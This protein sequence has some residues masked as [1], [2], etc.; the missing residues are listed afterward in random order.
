[1][2][3]PSAYAALRARAALAEEK[4]KIE[5]ATYTDLARQVKRLTNENASLKED[6]AFF[7]SL[8]TAGNHRPAGLSVNRFTLEKDGAPGKYRYR[9]LLVQTGRR[10]KEFSGRL[11]FVLNLQQGAQSVV[12][13]LPQEG[14]KNVKDY[15]LGVK[16]FQ[17]VEGTFTI[18]PEAVVKGMQVRVFENGSDTPK[19]TRSVDL[20]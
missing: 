16:F 1:M 10:P 9:L 13:T 4:L 7:Q 14:D 15:H 3:R 19:L 17:R 8:E 5:H 20:S 18:A 11:E 12:L 6:L 2:P